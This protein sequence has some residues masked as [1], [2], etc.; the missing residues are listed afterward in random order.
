MAGTAQAEAT[1]AQ[2]AGIEQAKAAGNVF[3]G[4]KPSY[5]GDQLTAVQTMLTQGAGV[6]SIAKETDQRIGTWS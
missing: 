4:R 2:K 3:P 1:H 5:S 6:S